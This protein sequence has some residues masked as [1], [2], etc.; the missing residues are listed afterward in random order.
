MK[1]LFLFVCFCFLFCF[2]F[3]GEKPPVERVTPFKFSS[4]NPGKYD[5]A[6]SFYYI[7]RMLSKGAVCDRN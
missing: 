3:F 2:C 6:T 4:Q 7:V 1:L 5:P